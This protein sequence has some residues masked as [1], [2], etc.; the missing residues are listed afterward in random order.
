MKDRWVIWEGGN[1]TI[2]W[3]LIRDDG[4][5]NGTLWVRTACG[6]ERMWSGHSRTADSFSGPT[7]RHCW[8]IFRKAGLVA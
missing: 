4:E 7:C 6:H 5:D 3:H 1:R 8:A 2:R